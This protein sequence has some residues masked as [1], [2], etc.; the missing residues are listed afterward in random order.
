MRTVMFLL[1]ALLLATP[2][3]ADQPRTDYYI[4]G[5]ENGRVSITI[6][7]EG[8][9]VRSGSTYVPRVK[10]QAEIIA[11]RDSR[12]SIQLLSYQQCGAKGYETVMED[13]VPQV[14]L[15]DLKTKVLSAPYKNG[16]H[17]VS[18][19]SETGLFGVELKPMSTD[20]F[21]FSAV[22]AASVVLPT[23]LFDR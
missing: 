3:A 20:D 21:D 7:T 22:S 11:W 12:G 18:L 2:A 19:P 6:S 8:P 4:N 10:C 13:L 5:V 23:G 17:F 15:F 1:L 9:L 14:W 16:L